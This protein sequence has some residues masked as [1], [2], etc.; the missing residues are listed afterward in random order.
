[1]SQSLRLILASMLV[2]GLSACAKDGEVDQCGYI[3]P[4]TQD[5]ARK[6]VLVVGDSISLGYFGHLGEQTGAD[7]QH[8]DCN[9]RNSTFGRAMIDQWLTV[10]PAFDAVVFNHGIWDNES[11]RVYWTTDEQYELNLRYIAR[12]IKTKT[13]CPIFLT[14][15]HSER[16]AETGIVHDNE[17]AKQAMAQEGVFVLDLHTFTKGLERTDGVHYSAENSAKIAHFVNDGITQF[18]GGI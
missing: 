14:T 17:L 9:G 1:M 13:S 3:A 4:V 18:C 11:E 10:R 5:D 16:P 7:V 8:H 2:A 12:V 6:D 15:S